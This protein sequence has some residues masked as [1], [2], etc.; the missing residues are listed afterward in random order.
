MTVLENDVQAIWTLYPNKRGI[1]EHKSSAL[2]EIR[3]AIERRGFERVRDIVEAYRAAHP[4]TMRH[5]V[6]FFRNL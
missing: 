3:L 1:G 6:G 5:A 2:N 4:V